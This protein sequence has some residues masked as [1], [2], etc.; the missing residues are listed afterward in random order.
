MKSYGPLLC[1]LCVC[2]HFNATSVTLFKNKIANYSDRSRGGGGG[3]GG[4]G[5]GGAE[6]PLQNILRFSISSRMPYHP[7]ITVCPIFH[8]KGPPS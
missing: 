4:A 6:P 8:T 1:A 5:G 7:V 2:F 3:G